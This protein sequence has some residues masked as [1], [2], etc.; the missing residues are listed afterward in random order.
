MGFIEELTRIKPEPDYGYRITLEYAYFNRPHPTSWLVDTNTILKL[1]DEVAVGL[2]E[3]L[4][5]VKYEGKI[6]FYFDYSG[7]LFEIRAKSKIQFNE[8]IWSRD[9]DPS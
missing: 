2:Y 7:I 6:L 4:K 3:K 9:A 8:V 5:Q 1:D